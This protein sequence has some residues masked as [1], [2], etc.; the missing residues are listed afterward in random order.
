MKS[1][2]KP[3]SG[4]WNTFNFGC[5]K[6]VLEY[7]F[8][9]PSS[10]STW[11]KV[12]VHLL[13]AQGQLT[14]VAGVCRLSLNALRV[15]L[16]L[17]GSP[18][19]ENWF[20]GLAELLKK[21]VECGAKKEV[22]PTCRWYVQLPQARLF[23]LSSCVALFTNVPDPHWVRQG[24]RDSCYFYHTAVLPFFESSLFPELKWFVIIGLETESVQMYTEA[25]WRLYGKSSLWYSLILKW[26]SLQSL[27]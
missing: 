8:I 1:K 18:E 9:F 4:D 13:E 20:Q 16:P 19:E 3:I 27:Y 22:I 17:Y 14:S 25:G 21:K 5:D 11:H 7:D 24:L 10:Q 15:E 2:S 26:S 6:E 12:A 23:S